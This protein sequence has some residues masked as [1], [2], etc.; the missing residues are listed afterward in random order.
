[1]SELPQFDYRLPPHLIAQQPLANRADARL[2]V[3]HR[4]RGS[5]EHR[6]VRDLPELLRSTDTLVSNNTR[7]VPARI[8]G[9]R[10][11][12]GGRWEGLFLSASPAGEWLLMCKTRGTPKPPDSIRLTTREGADDIKLWLLERRENG[13]WLARPETDEPVYALLDRI[14][15]V[16]LPPYIRQGKMSDS[17][18]ENYQTVFAAVPGAVAAPTAGLHFTPELLRK[19][20][21]IGVD[22][23]MVTLHVGLDTFRPITAETLDQHKMHSEW[24]QISDDTATAIRLRRAAGG[25]TIAIGT[26]SVRVLETASAGGE[27]HGWAG[28]TRLFIRP[29]YA[30]RGVDALM[31]NF[32]LP[33]T[34]LL[35]LVTAFAG[36]QLI[37]R[38]YQEA[39]REGYRFYSYGDAMLIF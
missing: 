2:M 18:R 16:P 23:R 14:G 31:T 24:G 21:E 28:E 26:T 33:Q 27:L 10:M 20:D 38:A 4:S 17:D 35:L 9:Y 15:R 7:V 29:P 5:V 6:H 19:V 12:T 13:I 30:F 1:M 39:I 22:R 34:T 8:L 36:D 25:R 37:R 3:V 32:H 11:A